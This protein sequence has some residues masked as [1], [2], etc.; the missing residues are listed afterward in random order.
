M[1]LLRRRMMMAL[2][3]NDGEE[4]GGGNDFGIEFPLYIEA[5]YCDSYMVGA[6]D[7]VSNSLGVTFYTNLLNFAIHTCKTYGE[8]N[9]GVYYVE[10]SPLDIHI[11][12]DVNGKW[13]ELEYFYA[14]NDFTYIESYHKLGEVYNNYVL[15][16]SDSINWGY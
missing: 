7:C 4:S 6:F 12:V 9:D 10:L 11:F 14:D 15:L 1:S 8:L 3:V 2:S 16:Y 5:D 13:S